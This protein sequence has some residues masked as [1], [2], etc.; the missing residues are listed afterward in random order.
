MLGIHLDPRGFLDRMAVELSRID[1]NEMKSL[2]DW[3][4]AAKES[5]F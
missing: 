4:R 1:A 3:D 5:Q 2:A